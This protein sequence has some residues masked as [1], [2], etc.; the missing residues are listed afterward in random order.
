MKLRCLSLHD[1][2]QDVRDNKRK[3]VMFGAG[4]IGQITVPEMLREHDLLDY[5]DCYIDNDPDKWD[6][7]ISL[8]GRSFNI[9]SPEYLSHCNGNAVV[10]INISRYAEVDRKSVV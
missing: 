5:I 3:I 1:I 9:K 8:Y 2:F 6:S 7:V 10:F 4:V